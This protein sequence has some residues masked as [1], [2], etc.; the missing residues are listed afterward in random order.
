[1]AMVELGNH[2]LT[3]RIDSTGAELASLE[4]FDT[5]KQLLWQGGEAWGRRAPVLFPI[6]GRMPGDTLLH[7]GVAYPIS[8]HGFARDLEFAVDRISDTEVGFTLEDSAVTLIHFPFS[9][10]LEVRF[11]LVDATVRTTQTVA[12][13]AS[14]PFSA[15]LGAH[16]GFAWPLPGAAAG[17][18]TASTSSCPRQHRS[19]ASR[20]AC[21]CQ[22]CSRAR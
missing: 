17:R 9:F 13:L 8:Q 20:M 7:D 11:E 5:G 15:S 2:S 12:N 4:L 1:M 10:R 6:I 22:N 3:L 19:D 18:I 14:E 21:S 16:P